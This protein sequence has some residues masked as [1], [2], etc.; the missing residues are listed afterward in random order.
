MRSEA[1]TAGLLAL[2]KALEALFLDLEFQFLVEIVCDRLPDRVERAVEGGRFGH[3]SII[4][5]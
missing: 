3:A 1:R 5:R 4:S 2:V